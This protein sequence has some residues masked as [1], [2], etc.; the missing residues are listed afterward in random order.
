M[1]AAND[2]YMVKTHHIPQHASLIL[3]HSGGVKNANTQTHPPKQQIAV[4]T[5]TQVV[6]FFL[7][8]YLKNGL[9]CYCA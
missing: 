8:H 3:S 5:L 9:P 6:D 4:F 1:L 7:I 2:K